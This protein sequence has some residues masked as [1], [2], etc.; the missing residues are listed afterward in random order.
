MRRAFIKELDKGS[1]VKLDD[2]I[3]NMDTIWEWMT[4]KWMRMV[5]E[6]KKNNI[7]TSPISSFW[8]KVQS[9]FKSGINNIIRKRNYNGKIN[10]LFKQALGCLSQAGA[11][12]MN[13]ENDIHFINSLGDAVNERLSSFYHSG[14]LDTRRMRLGLA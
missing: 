12:G 8:L 9:A 2:F 7:Q 13:N 14:D 5:D 1:Y 10:Q 4:T 11:M 6:I 3:D